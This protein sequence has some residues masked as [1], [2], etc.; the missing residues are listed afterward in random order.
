MRCVALLF[1][2]FLA[3]S[4][5]AVGLMGA[6]LMGHSVLT[7]QTRLPRLHDEG[8]SVA[9]RFG[10]GGVCTAILLGLLSYALARIASSRTS[11]RE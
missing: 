2:R 6:A 11:P 9:V 10:V 3:I 5:A 7:P 1:S 8:P 4:S